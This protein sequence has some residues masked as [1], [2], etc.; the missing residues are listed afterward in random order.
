MP[1]Y[2]C[3]RNVSTDRIQREFR[4]L[5]KVYYM[6]GVIMLG[7]HSAYF[8][9]FRIVECSMY[10]TF[11]CFVLIAHILCRCFCCDWVSEVILQ[12]LPRLSV[13]QPLCHWFIR[14]TQRVFGEYQSFDW[15][16]LF[17]IGCLCELFLKILH[18]HYLHTCIDFG[19]CFSEF[20]NFIHILSSHLRATFVLVEIR[21]DSKS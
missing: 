8:D 10:T 9:S 5:Q 13:C 7:V 16:L 21:R 18:C 1:C 4:G 11:S 20:Y 17:R 15:S 3:F 19:V 12:P 6:V 2:R 14:L